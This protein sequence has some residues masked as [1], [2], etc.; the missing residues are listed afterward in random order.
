MNPDDVPRIRHDDNTGHVPVTPRG[1]VAKVLLQK[2]NPLSMNR[3]MEDAGGDGSGAFI[4][5]ACSEVLRP[6]VLNH[7]PRLPPCLHAYATCYNSSE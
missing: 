6:F 7:P 1:R 4:R 5:L 3:S 2:E